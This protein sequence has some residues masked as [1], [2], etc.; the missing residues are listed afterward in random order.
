MAES[1]FYKQL[2]A[3]SQFKFY[4]AIFFYFA[5]MFLISVSLF[6]D[7]RSWWVVIMMM[8]GSGVI[9]VGYA[10]AAIR[11]ARFFAVVIPLHAIIGAG[12][13]FLSGGPMLRVSIL[14][15]ICVGVSVLGYVL[16][17]SFINGEGARNVRLQ[18][19]IDLAKQ[20]HDHLVPRIDITR[21]WVEVCGEASSSSEVGGDLIDVVESGEGMNLFIAD[22]S[23]HGMKAGVTM[24]MVKSAIRMELLH[25]QSLDKL[26]NDLNAVIHQVKRPEVFVTFACLQLTRDSSVR[27]VNAGHPQVLHYR[28]STRSID[29]L[30]SRAPGLG[31]MSG[32]TYSTQTLNAQ[33]GDIFILI[34]DGLIEAKNQSGE[35]FGLE[36]IKQIVTKNSKEPLAHIRSTIFHSTAT[37]G[38]QADDQT[39]LL[40]RLR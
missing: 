26:C 29:E 11:D 9:A 22:V 34:T 16:F 5:P 28:A 21:P 14:G 31:L 20:L 1:V 4:T 3:K 33:A 36:R 18:T 30:S 38:K 8:I 39:L 40:A 13:G 24:S 17:I 25:S 35:E 32:F 12:M 15:I 19:E 2:S 37:F 6:D 23:G 7:S 27:Y 10:F